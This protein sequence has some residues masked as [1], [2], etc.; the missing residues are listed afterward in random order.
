MIKC[1]MHM[2]KYLID[3]DLDAKCVAADSGAIGG[4]N[5]AEFMVKSEVGE[6]DVVFCTQCDYAANIEKA[7]S[8]AEKEE[9]Q[10][11]KELNKIETPNIKNY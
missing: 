10:E 5:S 7:S 6:D 1:M 2:L 8:P 11:F 3:V 9:K 4:A